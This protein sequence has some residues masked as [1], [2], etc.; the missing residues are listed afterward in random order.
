MKSTF[1]MARACE[2]KLNDNGRVWKLC[3]DVVSEF[4]QL[5]YFHK[6]FDEEEKEFQR[7]ITSIPLGN[8]EKKRGIDNLCASG[9]R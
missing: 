3:F 4:I 2:P 7:K 9:I 8:N 5:K 6:K 1:D